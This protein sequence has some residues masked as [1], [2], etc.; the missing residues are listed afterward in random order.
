ML[1]CSILSKCFILKLILYNLRD[2]ISKS[3]MFFFIECLAPPQLHN[4]IKIR[5]CK[6]Y[7]DLFGMMYIIELKTRAPKLEFD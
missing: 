4:S 1:S 7:F 2:L 3:T 5:R 6:I